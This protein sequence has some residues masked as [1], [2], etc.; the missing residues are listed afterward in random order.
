KSAT[1]GTGEVGF[2][3]PTPF[4]ALNYTYSASTV[5]VKPIVF[6]HTAS[7]P[8]RISGVDITDGGTLGSAVL[9]SICQKPTET[10]QAAPPP[11]VF[12]TLMSAGTVSIPSTFGL[13]VPAAGA[14]LC[15]ATALTGP[16]NVS[17]GKSMTP[18]VTLSARYGTSLWAVDDAGSS[19]TLT[20]S[21]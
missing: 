5:T 11:G 3:S 2:S 10:C 1:A 19:R 12:S 9:L 16:V 18:T 8:L 20:Q 14:T 6:A 13:M 4:S 21:V 15:L 17:A 7:L